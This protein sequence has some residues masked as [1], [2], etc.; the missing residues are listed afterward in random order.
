M[1]KTMEKPSYATAYGL[2]L[3]I[4]AII[5]GTSVPSWA[6][7]LQAT[8]GAGDKPLLSMH[9]GVPV[10]DIVAPN[11]QGL[12][13]NR[14]QQFNVG[15]QGVVINN[16][17][18]AGNTALAGHLQANAQFK[19]A[20]ASTILNEV[21]GHSRSNINGP[22]VIFG[23]AADYVLANPNGITLNG[24]R[25]ENANRAMFLVGSAQLQDGRISQ[26]DTRDAKGNLKIL[27]DGVNNPSGALALITPTIS[28]QGDSFSQGNT[29]LV[30]G[31]NRID[32]DTA[33]VLESKVPARY[34]DANLLGAMA[35]DN[36]IRIVSTAA[37]AGIKMPRSQLTAGQ[38]ISVV[39]AADINLEHKLRDKDATGARLNAGQGPLQLEA[40]RGLNLDNAQLNATGN[41]HLA[42]T[43]VRSQG[44][45]VHSSSALKVNAETLTNGALAGVASDFQGGELLIDVAGKLTDTGTRYSSTDSAIRIYA[46]SHDLKALAFKGAEGS[47]TERPQVG[48]LS[49][50]Q[51]IQ[52]QLGTDGRYEGAQLSSVEGPVEVRAGGRLAVTQA[53]HVLQTKS[54]NNDSRESTAVS[55]RIDTPG[56]VTL[57]AGGDM[58]LQG[59]EM[60]SAEHKL[61]GATLQAGGKLSVGASTRHKTL[62]TFS[63]MAGSDGGFQAQQTHEE[64]QIQTGSQ[65]HVADT[66]SLSA[67]AR[68]KQALN[69]EGLQAKAEHIK[70]KTTAGGIAIHAANTR[71]LKD[72]KS[73]IAALPGEAA[74]SVSLT[75][76][77][78]DHRTFAAASLNARSV[79][80]HSH[81]DVNLQG[82]SIDAERIDGE[83]AGNLVV[84]SLADQE[85]SLQVTGKAVM[86]EDANPL[87]LIN[88][89]AALGGKWNKSTQDKLAK[90]GK[91]HQPSSTQSLG[92]EFNKR[93][94]GTRQ[95]QAR[96]SGTDGVDLK[97]TGTTQ[98][99]GS[100]IESANGTVE[101][102]SGLVKH[103]PLGGL[104]LQTQHSVDIK[105]G[106]MEALKRVYDQVRLR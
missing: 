29:D 21:V 63:D 57:T 51:G 79:S 64:A 96:L 28:K 105:H 85:K 86:G 24:A 100:V 55:A 74:A 19:G 70:L 98:L 15:T 8:T 3:A 33:Q 66:L 17:L 11:A 54:I 6:N 62:K 7:G 23:A 106:D 56:Q 59:L 16:S 13:H 91:P 84:A 9:N 81:T 34:V 103:Q 104:D 93:D 97:V 46:G 32:Y 37:G 77:A 31:Y 10:I 53:N 35:S 73:V 2:Q 40:Q 65:W 61:G 82:A 90:I 75:A 18:E 69:L 36:R 58:S 43:A 38:G 25:I 22:Q 1:Q 42:G 39:S 50:R 14:F 26:L 89:V 68:H 60:G 41:I 95:Q 48:T 72:N 101:L 88:D 78:V 80:L 45:Q 49:A 71:D 12:S 94:H 27:K 76:E 4:A 102:G 47:T 44:A 99:T 52:V 83:I 30:L 67:S 87:G 5:L 92:F 20:A